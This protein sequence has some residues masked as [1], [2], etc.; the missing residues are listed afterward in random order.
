MKRM[1]PAIK[2]FS[3]AVVSEYMKQK[4]I[5][6][7]ME[8]Q[9]EFI[10]VEK[11]KSTLVESIFIGVVIQPVLFNINKKEEME[12]LDGKQRLSSIQ[13]YT[14]N[15]FCAK[16]NGEKLWYSRVSGTLKNSGRRLTEEE[17][18]FFNSRTIFCVCYPGLNLEQQKEVFSR[19]QNGTKL[20]T[21]EKI[22]GYLNPT[23]I[24]LR[25]LLESLPKAY[26]SGNRKEGMVLMA[27]LARLCSV[28]KPGKSMKSLFSILS[29]DSVMDWCREESI[30]EKYMI[31]I[32]KIIC[33]MKNVELEKEQRLPKF[34][35]LSHCIFCERKKLALLSEKQRNKRIS[36]LSESIDK[37]LEHCTKYYSSAFL[38]RYSEFLA[39]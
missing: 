38:K 26:F 5:N 13:D 37:L 31:E 19:I 20:S 32:E 29:T 34:L 16:V 35:Y 8:Y 9:R 36:S 6:M 14:E 24:F 10:W 27:R 11:Q 4:K 28:M 23:T 22:E 25:K 33:W 30:E 15:K 3:L 1:E 17:R 12:V 7:D 21:G 2:S 18:E 39:E